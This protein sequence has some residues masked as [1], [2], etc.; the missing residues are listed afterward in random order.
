[1]STGRVH[2][3]SRAHGKIADILRA[4]CFSNFLRPELQCDHPEG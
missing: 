3:K 4:E 2:V 1:M